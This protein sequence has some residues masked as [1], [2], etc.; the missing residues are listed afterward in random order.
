[1]TANSLTGLRVSTQASNEDAW[2]PSA[3]RS[4]ASVRHA[5]CDSGRRL[6]RAE[7]DPL[8]TPALLQAADNDLMVQ[9]FAF[10]QEI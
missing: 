7:I 1:M 4:S 2:F 6:R 10:S 8:Y 3:A 9:R 5:R